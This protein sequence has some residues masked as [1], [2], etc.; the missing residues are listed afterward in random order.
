MHAHTSEP[1]PPRRSHRWL[2]GALL[3]IGGVALAG[4][5]DDEPEVAAIATSSQYDQLQRFAEDAGDEG[6]E[7]IQVDAVDY[8]FEGLPPEIAA[9]TM[10]T[11]HNVSDVELH[12]LVAFLLPDDETRSAEEI[13]TLPEEEL[14]ALFAG[15]PAAVLLAMPGEDSFP[16]VGDGTFEEPGR[17]VV[18]CAIPQGADPE[19]FMAA[20]AESE[21]GPPQVDGGP[22]HFVFGMVGEFT[23]G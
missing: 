4:C 19:E 6:P 3:A 12:E 7:A 11:L 10:L 22:P 2:A 5:G 23:V 17:Y 8:A 13:A 15:E 1:L 21:G 16:A 14:G 18:F 9:G 20:A